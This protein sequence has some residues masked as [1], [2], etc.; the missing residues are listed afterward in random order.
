[1]AAATR[2][3]SALLKLLLGARVDADKK[4]EESTGCCPE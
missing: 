4:V 1:M 2:G 3:K